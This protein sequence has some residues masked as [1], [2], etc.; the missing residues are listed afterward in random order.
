MRDGAQATKERPKKHESGLGFSRL[1]YDLRHRRQRFRQFVGVALVFLFTVLGT[2]S[3]AGIWIGGA[4]ATAG[5]AIRLWA[6][7]YV[8][9]NQVLATV[10]PYARV[11]HPLYVGNIVIGLGFCVASGLWWSYPTM[12]AVLLYFYP[13]TIRYEDQKLKRL[14]P[15][16][17]ERWAERTRALLPSLWAY[18]DGEAA[19]AE[20]P[21]WSLRLSFRKNGEPLHIAIGFACLAY[22]YFV[23]L[24]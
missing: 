14:F 13:H 21:E 8:L 1:L 22:L 19:A 20:R 6:S 12:L 18:R 15:G 3:E 2:P 23:R 7:G 5:M 24:P 16:A 11:R 9:K 4:I 10:G 17:W